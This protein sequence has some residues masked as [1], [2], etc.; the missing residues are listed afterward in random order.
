MDRGGA[1]AGGGYHESIDH[2]ERICMTSTQRNL[3]LGTVSGRSVAALAVLLA[4]AACSGPDPAAEIAAGKADLS[5]Q[6]ARSAV[7]RFKTAIQAEPNS[8]ETRY[9]LGTALLQ[10]GDPVGASV[11]LQ[12]ALDQGFDPSRATPDLALALLESGQAR[13]LADQFATTTL[14]DATAQAA[15]KSRLASAWLALDEREKSADAVEAALKASPGFPMALVLKSRAVATKGDLG[16][17]GNLVDQALA[18]GPKLPE[19]WHLKGELLALSPNTRE[20]AAAM[21]RKAIE[22]RKDFVPAYAALMNLKIQANDLPG[23]QQVAAELRA[24]RPGHPQSRFFDAQLAFMAGDFAKAQEQAQLL[25]QGSPDHPGVLQLAGAIEGENG[26][27]VR[28]AAYFSKSVQSDPLFALSRISLAKTQLRLGQANR[29]LVTLRPLVAEDARPDAEALSLAGG[30]ALR[31]G[32]PASAEA[33]FKRA[34]AIR[35]D[36]QE[37]LTAIALAQLAKGDATAALSRL[38][39]LSDAGRQTYAGM[40]LVSARV[41]RRE[42][43]KALEAVQALQAANPQDA[44]VLELM[45]RVQTMRRDYPAARSAFEQALKIQPTLFAATASL[46]A[47]ETLQRKPEAAEQLLRAAVESDPRNHLAYMALAQLKSRSGADV[48]EVRALLDQGIKVSPSEAGPRLQL[49]EVLLRSRQWDAAMQVAQE[50]A[51]VLPDDLEV[52]DA[53]GRTQIQAGRVEQAISTFRRMT[54]L[55][56]RSG[57]AHVR[58]ADVLRASGD[59]QR[60]TDS[61]RRAL[62][63]EPDLEIARTRLVETLIADGKPQEALAIAK[64]SQSVDPTSVMGYLLEGAIQRRLRKP[65]EAVAVYRTG[66]ARADY[67]PV[68]ALEIYRTLYESKKASE[69]ERF[70]DD[71]LK[72]T[73]DHAAFH[74]ERGVK[75]VFEQ[76]TEAA[77]RHFA[78]AVQAAPNHAM[79]LN[80]LAWVLAGQGKPGAVAYARR[81]VE[82]LPNQAALMDTLAMALAADGQ[83]PQALEVQ[84]NAAEVAPN[85]NGVRL[86]LARLAL[87]ADDKQLARQELDR[88]AALGPAFGFQNEVSKLMKR[89]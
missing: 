82:L 41:T 47:I 62:E 89:L 74:Y 84:K 36:D 39:T 88:L 61:L 51:S 63:I 54:G 52:Q 17:A 83:L 33:F 80:N 16:Q 9:L 77:E 12:R 46:A 2:D 78:K 58:L 68:I 53:L 79:A 66:L 72:R 21:Q 20:Q 4:L 7:V 5:R 1:A 86:N 27:L 15:L 28:A 19:A 23:A 57:K 42:F 14:P 32:D 25:L 87:Q 70:A 31:L 56:E 44:E 71:W 67:K 64:R 55:D 10:S 59:L 30:A 40:A 85:D 38:E 11:E 48:A 18:N 65:D 60:S 6:D 69:A 75:A 35:P 24:A 50:A 37:T 81:A 22:A 76:E 3:S 43:D 34:A 13:K 49:V 73:P 29:V 8:A 26:S 45:G